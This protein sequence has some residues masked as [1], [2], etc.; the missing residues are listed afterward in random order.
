VGVVT[1]FLCFAFQGVYQHNLPLDHYYTAPLDNRVERLESPP[2]NLPALLDR[3]GINPDS[4][5]LVFS[6]TSFQATKIGPRNPRAIYFNDDVA[7]GWVRGS[8]SLEIAATDVRQGVVFYT[9]TAGK[10]ARNQACLHCHQGPATLGVPGI[11]IGSVFAAPTG[12]PYSLPAIVTDHRTKFEDRWGG[13][14]VDGTHGAGHHRG[15][16]VAADP[17]EPE[18]LTPLDR[19]FDAAG[20]LAPTSDLVALMTFEH[21]TMMTNLITRAGWEA[22]MGRDVDIEPLV[23][24]MTFLEEAPLPEPIQGASTF[25]K[26]FPQRGPLREFDLQTRLFRYPVSYMIYSP[27]F[28]ALPGALRKRIYGRLI[29]ILS[30][31][32]R[33]PRFRVALEILRKTKPGFTL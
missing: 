28:D 4:Q 15:N 16:S 14:Y 8:A 3:L 26:S 32:G 1:A 7:V 24:Y 33:E 17:A 12:Q 23:R 10:I 11:F 22:R 31:K 29:E 18:T 5:M 19:K 21:Q 13:W 9:F 2:T 20:Y 30:E 27:A 25:S 6:K